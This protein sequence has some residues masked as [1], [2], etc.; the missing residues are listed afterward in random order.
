MFKNFKS[1]I[2][3]LFVGSK[4]NQESLDQLEELLISSDVNIETAGQVISTLA[5]KTI[6]KN[7]NI[8]E[9]TAHL[10]DILIDMLMPYEQ[11][12]NY[13]F[14]DVPRIVLMVGVNGSGK[15]TT[16]AKIANNFVSKNQSVLLVAADTFRAAATEQLQLWSEKI[17]TDFISETEGSD[18]ASIVY[19][20]V[21]RAKE[22]GNQVIIID[23]A[24]RLHNKIDLMD[25]LGKISR[26][27]KK[28]D[29][30]YP[31]DVIMTID[32]TT[33]QNA[34]KQVEEFNKYVTLT[35][36]I[37]S[38]FD[39]SASGGTLL[40]ITNKTKLPI[41]GLGIGENLEDLKDFISR[42]FVEEILKN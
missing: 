6:S 41:N 29:E 10:K 37:L 3:K 8:D 2:S 1:E 14:S 5:K 31:H 21:L 23:T 40:S 35:G 28:H 38:K 39:T 22:L 19:K 25:Q 4:I 11:T 12:L 32:A 30:K 20:S 34:L 18:P 36:I 16:I 17:G 42:D 26:V 27:L 15:T 24:G 9:I 13:Q 7:G 33:G